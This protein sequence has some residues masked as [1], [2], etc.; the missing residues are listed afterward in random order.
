MRSLHPDLSPRCMILSAASSVL[1][2][3]RLIIGDDSGWADL[4]RSLQLALAN[5]FQEQVASAY[6]DLSAMAVSR[7]Q[8]NE[9]AR[10]LSAGLAYCE[11]R[12]LDFLRPFLLAYRARM[13]F[14]QGHWLGASE[15]AETVLRHPR[16]TPVT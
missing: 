10:F 4:E 2:T 16:A 8:Y 5:G 6:T 7:R 13:K 9:A 11:E 1:G 3:A 12:H 14:E 15:D